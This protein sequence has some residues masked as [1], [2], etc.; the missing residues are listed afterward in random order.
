MKTVLSFLLTLAFVSSSFAQAEKEKKPMAKKPAAE[1]PAP[2]AAP[3]TEEAKPEETKTQKALPM[4]VRVDAI[5]VA[6][7]TFT[8]TRKKDKVSVKHVVADATEIKNSGVAAKFEDIKVGDTVAGSRIKKSDTEYD[9]VK[10]T[11]FGAAEKEKP[12]APTP[13]AE[14]AAKP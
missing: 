2:A 10:I 12:S 11:K 6:A 5:D 1:K 3:K 7:K 9:V 14:G 13:K 8:M 4:N